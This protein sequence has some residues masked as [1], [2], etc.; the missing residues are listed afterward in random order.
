MNFKEWLLYES[1]VHKL[2]IFDFDS[3]LANTPIKPDDW[4]GQPYV[5]PDGKERDEDDW[6]AHPDSLGNNYQLN[7][8]I[9]AE[10]QKARSDPNTRTALLT[11]RIGM[12]TAHMIRGRL[13]QSGLY[14]RRM[15]A[16]GY[17]KALE[18]AKKW[19]HGD[20]HPEDAHEE[21]Y[22]GDWAK[23]PNYP[24]SL[25]G[26]PA[27]DTF[28]HKQYVVEMLATDNITEIDFWDDRKEHLQGFVELFQ[29]LLSEK[30]NLQ[31][32]NIHHVENGKA[33][34]IPLNK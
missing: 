32:V 27:G 17:S 33:Q 12:R 22:K 31:R 13:R 5:A 28:T 29:K 25:R 34:L 6:W 18:R 20:D 16:P 8:L 2:A 9:L 3:T 19:P 26:G 4:K 21:Y 10:F 14:G 24:K 11:G 1:G 23:A 30:P 7:P 15:I